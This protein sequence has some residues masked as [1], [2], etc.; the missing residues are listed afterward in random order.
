MQPIKERILTAL[1]AVFTLLSM[2]IPV[3]YLCADIP[4]FDQTDRGVQSLC[5]TSALG[6]C[7]AADDQ[8]CYFFIIREDAGLK[9]EGKCLIDNAK[10]RR[11]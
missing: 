6:T 3:S 2:L 10:S 11:Y 7:T 8:C 1:C 5:Y 4:P 9:F